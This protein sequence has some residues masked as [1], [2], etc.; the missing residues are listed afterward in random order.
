MQQFMLHLQH[1]QVLVLVQ[2]TGPPTQ[3]A[4]QEVNNSNTK[5]MMKNKGTIKLMN[6]CSTLLDSYFGQVCRSVFFHQM[7]TFGPATIASE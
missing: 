3:T 4:E 5:T 2:V 6:E 1:A 7:H